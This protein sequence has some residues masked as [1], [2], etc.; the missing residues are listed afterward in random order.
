MIL[1][2]LKKMK[3]DMQIKF[4]IILRT[5]QR[6]IKTSHTHGFQNIEGL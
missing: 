6:Q 3:V 2:R 4:F 1:L 5:S